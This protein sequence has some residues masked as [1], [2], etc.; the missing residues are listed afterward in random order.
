[1]LSLQKATTF[2]DDKDIYAIIAAFQ[3]SPVREVFVVWNVERGRD[4][5][6]KTACQMKR[7]ANTDKKRV[8]RES[9]HSFEFL[10]P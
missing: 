3:I 6:P 5:L 10:A 9:D 1:M 7:A 2:K 4:I 8:V